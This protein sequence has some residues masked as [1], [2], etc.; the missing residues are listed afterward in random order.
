MSY[1]NF[2]TVAEV[3]RKFDIE[4]VDDFFVEQKTIRIA[5]IHLSELTQ[6]LNSSMNYI[7]EFTICETMESQII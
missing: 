7:N 1:G 6:K 3:A 5:E 2:K 4:V